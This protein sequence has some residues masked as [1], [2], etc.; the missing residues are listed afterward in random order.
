MVC[1]NK[2]NIV[3]AGYSVTCKHMLPW[4]DVNV[5]NPPGRAID[6]YFHI[7]SPDGSTFRQ[8]PCMGIKAEK[9]AILTPLHCC[10][11][12]PPTTL[13]SLFPLLFCQTCLHELYYSGQFGKITKCCPFYK[14]FANVGLYAHIK[15]HVWLC[16][17]YFS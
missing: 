4:N 9:Y 10:L 14:H 7:S 3:Q 6:N 17:I 1:V 5:I 11:C 2:S 8:N 16:K 13:L 12:F 15:Q